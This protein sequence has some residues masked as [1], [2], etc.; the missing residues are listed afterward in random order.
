MGH[1]NDVPA[2]KQG[3]EHWQRQSSL[4]GHVAIVNTGCFISSS[5]HHIAQ[6][7]QSIT[8]QKSLLIIS[9]DCHI[10][11]WQVLSFLKQK[12]LGGTCGFI[13]KFITSL[14]HSWKSQLQSNE[15]QKRHQGRI[16]GL[17]RKKDR[18]PDSVRPTCC[19]VWNQQNSCAHCT[20]PAHPPWWNTSRGSCSTHWLSWRSWMNHPNLVPASP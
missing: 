20:M 19:W 3:A 14:V 12:N 6:R 11:V 8:L 13:L 15:K 1:E 7:H 2:V 10:V 16:A 17:P 5:T 18:L 4:Y 9:V